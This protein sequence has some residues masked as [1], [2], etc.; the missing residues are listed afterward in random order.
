MEAL[1]LPPPPPPP[2][3]NEPIPHDNTTSPQEIKNRP[4][5]PSQIITIET[6]DRESVLWC[7][8]IP[9]HFQ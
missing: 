7:K 6:I 9:I 5:S 4:S 1:S 3:T 2:P 8:P